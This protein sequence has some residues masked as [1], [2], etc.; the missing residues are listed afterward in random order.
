VEE[1]YWE[2][3]DYSSTGAF[4]ETKVEARKERDTSGKQYTTEFY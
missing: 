1:F 2:W 4:D 3:R